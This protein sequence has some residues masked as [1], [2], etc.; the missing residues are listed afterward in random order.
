MATSLKSRPVEAV[1]LPYPRQPWI[2]WL[3][4][5]PILLWRL[6]L[7]VLVGRLFMIMTTTGRKTGQPRH[8]AIEYHRFQGRLMICSAWGAHSQ[9]Y[10]NL[11]AD[12]RVTIQTSAGTQAMLARRLITEAD[13]RLGYAHVMQNPTL[14]RWFRALG[15]DLT[16]EDF[17]ARRSTVY[18]LTFEPTDAPTPPGVHMDLAWAWGALLILGV[19]VGWGRRR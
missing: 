13:L 8:T 19:L 3:Y 11:Q 18:L 1:P 5:S 15:F 4:K 12:P 7:G 14:Q 9:W 17:W 2:K 16:W 6:G 10:K